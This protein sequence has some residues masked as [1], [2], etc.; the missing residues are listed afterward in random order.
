MT[1]LF[2]SGE[3][4]VLRQ[5]IVGEGGCTERRGQSSERACFVV[6]IFLAVQ[7]GGAQYHAVSGSALTEDGSWK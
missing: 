7:R 6:V 3:A 5:V 1:K 4:R 2:G